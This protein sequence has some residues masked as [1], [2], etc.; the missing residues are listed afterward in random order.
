[1]D[2]RVTQMLR[3]TENMEM[4]KKNIKKNQQPPQ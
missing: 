4:K 3:A 2:K 1:M